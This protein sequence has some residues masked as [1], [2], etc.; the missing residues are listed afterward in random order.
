MPLLLLLPPETTTHTAVVKI[1]KQRTASLGG[2]GSGWETH[3][4][5]EAL[6]WHTTACVLSDK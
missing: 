2:M 3:E 5:R 4:E 6:N 1:V